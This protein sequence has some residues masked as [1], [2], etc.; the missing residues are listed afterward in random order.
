M[1]MVVFLIMKS[2]SLREEQKEV[3]ESLRPQHLMFN[4]LAKDGLERWVFGAI[5]KSLVSRNLPMEFEN[6][7]RRV[8]LSYSMVE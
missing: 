1:M 2:I 8:L 4:N 6:M 5:I 3:L 7:G